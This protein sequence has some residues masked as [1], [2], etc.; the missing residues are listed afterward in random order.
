MT[1]SSRNTAKRT[2][3]NP[4]ALVG[5]IYAFFSLTAGASAQD[6]PDFS[7]IWKIDASQS[8]GQGGGGG[9]RRGPGN[10]T[11]G[12]IGL[13][14]SP[15]DLTIKQDATTVTIEQHGG[16][17]PKLT[18]VYNLDGSES[19]TPMTGPGGTSRQAVAKATWRDD[20]LV[21]TLTTHAQPTGGPTVVYEEVRSLDRDG[22][23]VVETTIPGR[24]GAR[25][26]IYHRAK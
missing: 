17:G 8:A 7:G 2:S 13:G 19:K 24:P 4:T 25:R 20:K 14:P 15:S 18:V 1:M 22:S 11:G 10:G 6:R 5:L 3:R 16:G 21:T 9:A 12:G 23:M 26:V